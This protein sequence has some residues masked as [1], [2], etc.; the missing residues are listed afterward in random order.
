M[1]MML[2]PG[3]GGAASGAVGIT[4]LL[5]KDVT[6]A[7][8]LQVAGILCSNTTNA[9]QL[10]RYSD[11]DLA[12]GARCDIANQWPAEVFCSIHCNAVENPEAQGFEVW[13][14]REHDAAD[15]LASRIWLAMRQAFPDMKARLDLSDGDEDWEAGY[16]V[17][18][19][20]HMPA[21][22]V[23]LAFISN[24][25]D[26]ERLRSPAWQTR[27]AMVIADVLRSWAQQTGR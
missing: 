8:A 24:P 22:L 16:R 7:V 17:L 15:D 26:E 12:L 3:H 4:G 5:E 20:T 10:T 23:E 11:I 18:V 1:N 9:V 14:N 27:A 25:K 2:D 21:V 19:G 6:L 13:T